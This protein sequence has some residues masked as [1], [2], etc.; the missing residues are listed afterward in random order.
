MWSLTRVTWGGLVT[1]SCPTLC[2]P[3]D[4][5]PPGSSVQEISQAR[6]LEWVAISFSRG[7]SWPRDWTQVSCI[8]GGL[9]HCRQTLYWLNHQEAWVTLGPGLSVKALDYT[10]CPC[11]PSDE[12]LSRCFMCLN[13]GLLLRVAIKGTKIGFGNFHFGGAV[14]KNPPANAGDPRD[15]GSI[16]GSGRSPE[17]GN[18]NSLQYSC[19]ENPMDRRAWQAAIH[20]V[21]KNQMWLSMQPPLR[22]SRFGHILPTSDET[23]AWGREFSSYHVIKLE[24]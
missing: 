15:A 13:Q 18:G 22:S 20:G 11:S 7:S 4:C 1:L 8:V 10:H 5:S 14:V 21:S 3:M 6:I 12:G 24:W 23:I 16:L 9:L 19:L 2:D 17:L